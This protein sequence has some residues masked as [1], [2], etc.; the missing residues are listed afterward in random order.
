MAGY[1]DQRFAA[2]IPKRNAS[3]GCASAGRKK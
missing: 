2:K 3:Y 1:Q